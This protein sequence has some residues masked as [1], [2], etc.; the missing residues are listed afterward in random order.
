MAAG[1]GPNPAQAMLANTTGANVANQAALMAGQRGAGQNVGMIA[2]QAAQQGGNL[3]QQAA[4]Q[5]AA[6][7]AQQSQNAIN[8]AGAMANQQVANQQAGTGAVTSANL[9]NQQNLLNSIAGVNSAN[10]QQQAGINQANAG[11][12]GQVAT[13][14]GNMLGNIAGGIG[15][16]LMLMKA[17]GGEVEDPNAAIN[18]AMTEGDGWNR[19]GKAIGYAAAKATAAPVVVPSAP[20]AAP[21]SGSSK[22]VQARPME[23]EGGSVSYYQDYFNG[24]PKMAEGGAVPAMVSPGEKYLPPAAVQK[25]AQGASPMSEGKTIPGKPKVGGAQ[26]NYANDTVKATLQDGGIVLP[27]SVTQS[28]NPDKNAEAFV[29]AILA[30]K[31]LKK[32][33]K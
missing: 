5:G 4:G 26:N 30:K 10:V 15:T 28:K 1:R 14:Q 9:Q 13:G 31:G 22:P 18:K 7:Q 32:G 21:D 2:R 19:A 23:A 3:Q 33:L 11:Y 25:V 29:K 6:L 20:K 17:E 8:S 12:A 27:R 24:T 16:G